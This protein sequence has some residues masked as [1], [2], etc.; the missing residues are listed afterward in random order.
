MSS[1]GHIDRKK[2]DVDVAEH[3]LAGGI[4]AEER[5]EAR[6]KVVAIDAGIRVWPLGATASAVQVQVLDGDDAISDAPDRPRPA[7]ARRPSPP[8]DRER[9]RSR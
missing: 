5:D 6:A 3:V 4:R 7:D 1:R 9:Y 8:A 2:H